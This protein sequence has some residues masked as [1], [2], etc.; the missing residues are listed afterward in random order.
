MAGF[1]IINRQYHGAA[2]PLSSIHAWQWAGG[3]IG[4]ALGGFLDGV[5]FE[6]T[7]GYTWSISMAALASLATLPFTLSLPGKRARQPIIIA[8]TSL[9]PA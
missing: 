1:P 9:Q 2:A 7:G 4:M 8:E 5:L 3:M 6:L